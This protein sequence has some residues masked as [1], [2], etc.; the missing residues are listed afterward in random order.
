MFYVVTI[1]FSIF[2]IDIFYVK[3]SFETM[4]FNGRVAIYHVDNHNSLILRCIF[5]FTLNI[6]E[7]RMYLTIHN[8]P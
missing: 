2:I 7:T 3:A 1:F 6:S 8:M 5:I 4:N